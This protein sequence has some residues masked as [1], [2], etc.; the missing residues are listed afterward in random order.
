MDAV[1]LQ[2]PDHLQAGA[3]AD[4]RQARVPVSAEVALQDAA[5]GG[6]IEHRAPGLEL[7][8]AVGRLLRMQFGHAPVVDVL[9]TPHRV[10]EMDLPVVA[11]VDIRQRGGDAAFRH[12]RVCLAQE[13][14]AD[15]ADRDAAGGCFDRRPQSRAARTD[16][17][18]VV[19]VRLIVHQSLR[20]V[21]LKP[22]TTSV[23]LAPLSH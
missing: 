11:V 4:V 1:I 18:H 20:M 16:N 17:E 21:R 8:D 10:G 15:E 23:R 9:A 12:H 7:A 6:A 2:G 13:G 3:V 5:V 22:D 14:F 19:L